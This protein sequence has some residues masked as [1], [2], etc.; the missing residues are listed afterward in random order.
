MDDLTRHVDGRFA[1]ISKLP[2]FLDLAG[3][4]AVLAGN[5]AG[6]AWKAELIAAAG[7]HVQVLA[8]APGPEIEALVAR[9]SSSGTLTLHRR[10]WTPEDLAGAAIAVADLDDHEQARAFKAA[11][12]LAGVIVNTIDKGA[13][14]DFYFGAIVS[15]TPI[16]IGMTTDGTAPILGQAMRRK[17][18]LTLPV[19]LGDWADLARRIRGHVKQ[20]LAPG[21]QRRAFWEDFTERAFAAPPDAGTQAGVLARIDGIVAATPARGTGSLRTIVAQ[22]DADA[23]TLGDIKA[24]QAA[25]LILEE[26][27]LSPQVRAFFRREATILRLGDTGQ[28]GSMSPDAA[29]ARIHADLARGLRIVQMLKAS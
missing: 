6:L 27:G 13:T 15:R 17:V 8:P 20:R 23:L 22:A 12:V 21:A 3:R 2:I 14:C 18:E 9:G 4:R 10:G 24:M 5:T 29:H 26:P 28:P 16:I 7:A 25:D 1:A 11:G 19:W